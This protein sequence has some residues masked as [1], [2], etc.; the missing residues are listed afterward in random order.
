V[1]PPNTRT[2]TATA[3]R[4]KNKLLFGGAVAATA[5]DSRRRGKCMMPHRRGRTAGRRRMVVFVVFHPT[6]RGEAPSIFTKCIEHEI[7]VGCGGGSPFGS[8]NRVDQKCF[9]SPCGRAC[10]AAAL[11]EGG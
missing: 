3:S 6:D 9:Q 4:K 1:V 2:T 7:Q 8:G 10:M 11:V 5:T